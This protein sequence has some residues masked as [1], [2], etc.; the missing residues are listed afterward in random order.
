MAANIKYLNYFGNTVVLKNVKE[1]QYERED[2]SGKE[3]F[4]HGKAV[5]NVPITLDFSAGV[6]QIVTSKDGYLMK[7]AV[8]IKPETLTEENIAD[9]VNVAGIVGKHQGGGS[10]GGD[11]DTSDENITRYIYTI[12][13]KEKT[14]TLCSPQYDVYTGDNIQFHIPS[15]IGGYNVIVNSLGVMNN[16]GFFNGGG[17]SYVTKVSLDENVKF[18]NDSM[19]LF[20]T[21]CHNLVNSPIRIPNSVTNVVGMLAS[22][23]KFNSSVTFGE[24]SMVSSVHNMFRRCLNFNQPVSMPSSVTNASYMFES[25]YN[26]NQTV[27]LSMNINNAY[28]MFK[29]CYNFNKPLTLP[30]S[31]KYGSSMFES[32][33]KFNQPVTIP[34]TDGSFAYMFS[35][36]TNFNSEVTF[37]HSCDQAKNMFNN[38]INFNSPI[39]FQSVKTAAGMFYNCVKFNH[40]VGEIGDFIGNASFAFYNCQSFNQP[41]VIHAVHI[42]STFKNCKNMAQNIILTSNGLPG[43]AYYA[44]NFLYGKNN[45]KRINIFVRPNSYMNTYIAYGNTRSIFGAAVIWTQDPENSC[46]YCAERNVYVYYTVNTE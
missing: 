15:T 12:S 5:E 7:S 10:G 22:S 41:V 31:L 14:I 35:G 4:S 25:C 24:K 27:N 34:N 21:S 3:P 39:H 23:T 46:Y 30:S 18:A 38:C 32:C 17:Q 8:I 45:Y 43:T 42:N 36:C 26:F 20:L 1:L 9:G 37:E 11:F 44:T 13:G 6:D 29:N 16:T 19:A 28:G 40:P 2:G 33:T